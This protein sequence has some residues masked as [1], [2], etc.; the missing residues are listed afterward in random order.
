[1]GKR[2][3]KRSDRLWQALPDSLILDKCRSEFTNIN[4][5]CMIIS[6][7]VFVMLLPEVV[8]RTFTNPHN[9]AEYVL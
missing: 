5:G 6:D 1:M 3:S 9:C 8:F 4:A 7:D 2:S